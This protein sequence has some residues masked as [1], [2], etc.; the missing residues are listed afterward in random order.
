MGFTDTL[1]EATAAF[2]ASFKALIAAGTV[3]C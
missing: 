2:K 1:D 3:K